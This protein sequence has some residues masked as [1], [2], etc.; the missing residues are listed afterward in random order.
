VC[1]E[2]HLGDASVC[3]WFLNSLFM[4]LKSNSKSSDL[5]AKR[6]CNPVLV[7]N[8]VFTAGA[9][10]LI[11]GKSVNKRFICSSQTCHRIVEDVDVVVVSPD[12]TQ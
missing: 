3:P 8:V 7:R 6:A 1:V 5:T 12:G 4:Y 10:V 11:C 2:T 9:I